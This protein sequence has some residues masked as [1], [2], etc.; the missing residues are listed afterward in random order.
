MRSARRVPR[1]AARVVF[2]GVCAW[3]AVLLVVPLAALVWNVAGSFG[4]VVVALTTPAALRALALSLVIALACIVLN[5]IFGVA[6][7][8]VIVRHRFVG[9]RVLDAFVDLPLAL[10]PVMT[11]LGFLLVFG[12]TGVL[13]PVLEGL[14]VQI[15]FAWPSVLLATLFVTL[16]FALREVALVL[17]EVGDSE[18]QAAATLGASAWQTFRRVTLPNVRGGLVIGTTLTAAR[19]LGEFGAVLV[20][21]GAIANRTETATTFIHG[22]IEER[23]EPAA[24]G[25]A[26]L[27]AAAAIALL[28]ILQRDR[29]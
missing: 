26:L 19:A 21:G 9:R 6:G 28:F 5:G 20:V 25:M 18:E 8:V 12:R 29:E 22:A 13:R 10:S 17:E 23:Q 1:G 3:L 2:L 24:Y 27:L 14:G 15:V 16:P 11:G 4:D 7:A